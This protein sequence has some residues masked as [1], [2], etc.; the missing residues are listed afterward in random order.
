MQATRVRTQSLSTGMIF[1]RAIK[2]AATDIGGGVRQ[3]QGLSCYLNAARRQKNQRGGK[4]HVPRKPKG[5]QGCSRRMRVPY[6]R[7]VDPKGGWSPVNPPDLNRSFEV[8]LKIFSKKR[9][10]SACDS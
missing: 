3:G 6:T 9:C 10:E 8:R 5:L 2:G 4:T 7:C 1:S